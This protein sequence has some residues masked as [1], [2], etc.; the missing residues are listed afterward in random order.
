MK[1]LL[2]LVP[3]LVLFLPPAPDA[4]AQA[5]IT[6]TGPVWLGTLVST[7]ASVNNTAATNIKADGTTAAITW[8]STVGPL[9]LYI[10]C[11]APARY[12]V[13]AG[14]V[15][16]SLTRSSGTFGLK[17]DTDQAMPFSMGI[18]YN[19]AIIPISG[20]VNCDVY[21]RSE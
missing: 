3:L 20:S 21:Q 9:K 11:D 6:P 4:Q 12:R 10:Q 5:I 1:R 16:I 15:A 14:N 18:G 2:Y 19:L 17:V 8:P 7:G 13:A